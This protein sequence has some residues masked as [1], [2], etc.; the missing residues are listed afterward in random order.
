MRFRFRTAPAIGI[1]LSLGCS[2]ISY[3]ETICESAAVRDY[4]PP[5]PRGCQK[6]RIEAAGPLSLGILRSAENLA[7]KAWQHQVL[8]L[9]GERFLDWRN[10][11]CRKVVCVH[12]SFAGSR[13][14]M[15][16]AFPCAADAD[17]A[18]IESLN[19]RQAT[20]SEPRNQASRSEPHN[21]EP[22]SAAEIREMQQ[23]L[24][25][26]GYHVSVDGIFG[27][28]TRKALASWLRRR[29]VSYDGSVSREM[30]EALRSPNVNNKIRGPLK[31]GQTSAPRQ[32]GDE[33]LSELEIKEMQ[34]LLSG[35]GYRVWVDGIFGDR[36]RE[37]LVRRLRRRGFRDG[38]IPTRQNLEILRR[39]SKAR[40]AISGLTVPAPFLIPERRLRRTRDLKGCRR[41]ERSRLCGEPFH[42]APRPGRHN[43]AIAPYCTVAVH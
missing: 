11:A 16:S 3:A 7:W 13:R 10:A 29:G 2:Q 5:L 42:A 8:T 4:L 9:Y 32:R 15:T 26:A 6:E 43:P 38:G 39:I 35:A 24:S 33:S 1:L 22:L 40:L 17:H 14:C 27:D 41:L 36:T 31:P 25:E 23:L 12:A 28:Q 18:A 19:T 37:A 30:L 21:N 20:L 34:Q